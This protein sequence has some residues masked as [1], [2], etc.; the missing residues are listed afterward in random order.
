MIQHGCTGHATSR[1]AQRS[2]MST[3][4]RRFG[5]L[6]QH[7]NMQVVNDHGLPF[8]ARQ[9]LGIEADHPWVLA[10]VASGEQ[11]HGPG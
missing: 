8:E 4:I 1:A 10:Q 7:P 11:F 9:A 5:F 2:A 3:S 6:L